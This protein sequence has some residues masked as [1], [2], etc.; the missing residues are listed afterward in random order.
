MK[1]LKIVLGI[2]LLAGGVMLS[3]CEGTSSD[4]AQFYRSQIRAWENMDNQESQLVQRRI[5]HYR[6][7]LA[8]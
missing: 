4:S 5:V 6:R 7:L 1:C 2:L 3:G 8:E